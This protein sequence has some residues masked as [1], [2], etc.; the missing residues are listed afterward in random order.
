MCL[1]VCGWVSSGVGVL[2]LTLGV[3]WYTIILYII[4]YIT[5]I[6]YYYLIHILYSSLPSSSSLLLYPL[7]PL[8]PFLFPI[9]SSS[10]PLFFPSSHI[11]LI[12]SLSNLFLSFL[13]IHS[14]LVG[15]YIYLFYTPP[16]L[17]FL[18]L[19]FQLLFPIFILL[20]F[21]IPHL[22]INSFYTC[23]Y[24]HILIYIQ[25]SHPQISDP[26]RSIGV[27]G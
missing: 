19:L 8:L 17:F 2:G 5:I 10:L 1:F 18:I 26:A 14:I 24:L 11:I 6:I 4:L 15:T 9:S 12:S 16:L 13:N 3:I 27:D 22:S 20:L 7:L 23:R 21:F 25:S